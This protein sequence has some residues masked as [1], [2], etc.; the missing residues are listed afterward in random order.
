MVDTDLLSCWPNVAEVPPIGTS[1]SHGSDVR[2]RSMHTT[3][4]NSRC[5]FVF[6]WVKYTYWIIVVG[7]ARSW[8]SYHT[9]ISVDFALPRVW[10]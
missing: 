1:I 7:Q 2:A 9:V 6:V 3:L 5:A 10:R 8:R 4:D